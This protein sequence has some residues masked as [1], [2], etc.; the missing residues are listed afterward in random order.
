MKNSMR[1]VTQ[2][3]VLLDLRMKL[4]G[5]KMRNSMKLETQY[6]VLLDLNSSKWK[7]VA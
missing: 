6:K 7:E 2:F 1:L 5:S 3:K 4:V